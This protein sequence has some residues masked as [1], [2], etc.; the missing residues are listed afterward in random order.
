[1]GHSCRTLLWDTL[2]TLLSDT[3][4][5]HS[6]RTL[7]VGHSCGHHHCSLQMSTVTF[8]RV[9]R[10]VCKMST[11]HETSSKIHSSSRTSSISHMSKSPKRAFR[12]RLPPRLPRN[13]TS[14]TPRSLTIPCA[15][16]EKCTSTPQNPHKVL[17]L[18]RKVTISDHASF[19]FCTTP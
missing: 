6:C 18:L 9:T 19:K 15:C 1:M 16:H 2:A 10:Q 17:R 4:V 11:S 5:G 12:T 3:L 14:A 8:W 7:L 13:A